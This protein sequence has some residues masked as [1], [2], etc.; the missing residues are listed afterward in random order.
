M[1]DVAKS[2]GFRHGQTPVTGIEDAQ[3]LSNVKIKAKRHA[4][5]RWQDVPAFYSDVQTRDDM[6]AKVLMLV[7]PTGS[8]IGELLGVKCEELDFDAMVRTGPSGRMKER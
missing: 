8:P 4:A 6:A 2:R 7:C 1:L 5:M 3:V